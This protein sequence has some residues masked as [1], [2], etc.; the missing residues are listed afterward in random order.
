MPKPTIEWIGGPDGFARIIDQTL[1]PAEY[2]RVDIRTPQEMFE[3]IGS[4]RVRG[5]PAIGIAGACGVVLAGGCGDFPSEEALFAGLRKAGAYLG[6]S[7]PTAVNLAWAVERVLTAAQ[8]AA[9]QGPAAVRKAL[10]DEALA[11]YEEDRAVCRQIGEAGQ[12][13]I[14]DGD[15]VLTHCNAGALATADYG[16]ALAVIYRA[17]E[18]GKTVR[19]YADETRPLLQGA[20]LTAW[21]LMDEG[22]DVTLVCDDMAATLMQSGKIDL[23]ITGADRI[24]A[25]G[26]TANKIG[27]LGLA[28]VA[29]EFSVPFYIA[30]PISTFDLDIPNGRAIPIEER[31][32]QEV[33][34]GFGRRTAPEGVKVFNPAFDVTPAGYITAIVTE[35]GLIRN[36]DAASIADIAG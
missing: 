30:A 20:R 25:N 16:T 11:I 24:A 22:V 4:L 17:G 15:T 21:E 1:L 8:R 34:E 19:V 28:V 9:G 12:E 32:S 36:P 27:T 23:V 2:K 18:L 35:R 14:A 31:P 10:L 33:T 13:I 7:R 26:D 5:A 6:S 29:K 3:A